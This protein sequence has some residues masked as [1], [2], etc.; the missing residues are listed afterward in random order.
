MTACQPHSILIVEDEGIVAKDMQQTLRELGYDAYAIASG[1]DDAVACASERCPDLVLMDIRIKGERDGIETAQLL[2]DRFAVPIVYLTAH[3]DDATL[4]RAKLTAPHGYLVKPVK[5]AELRSAIEVSLYKHSLEKRQQ[6]RE[7]WYATTL[8][9]IADAVVAVDVKGTVTFMNPAAEQLT[10]IASDAAIGRPAR[11]VVRLI[12]EAEAA[13]P[14]DVALARGTVVHLTEAEL[15]RGKDGTRTISDSVAPVVDE[16]KTLGAVMVFR[17]V[18]EQR[19]LQK[20]LEFADRLASLGTMAAGVAHEVNNPLTVVIGNVTFARDELARVLGSL[21]ATGTA[22]VSG[23]TQL[24][25]ASSAL[26][27]AQTAAER[28]RQV[29]TDLRAFARPASG[30]TTD[31]DVEKAL[32][33]ALRT[34]AHEFRNRAS[35]VRD[36]QGV[37]RVALDEARLGQVLI[38]L[39]VNAAHAIEPG[40]AER[41][42]VSIAAHTTA[43]GRVAIEVRDTGAGIPAERQKQIFEPFFTTKGFGSGT[44]LGLSI[45]HGIVSSAG[46]T[47]RVDSSVGHG[48]VFRVMLPASIATRGPSL[49]SD[50]PDSSAAETVR[51]RVLLIDDEELILRTLARALR[52]H[53]VICTESARKALQLLETEPRFDVIFS[54]LMMPDMTGMEFYE[55]LRQEHPDLCERVV[56]VSGGASSPRVSDFLS[57]VSNLCVDKPFEL[58]RLKSIVRQRVSANSARALQR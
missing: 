4:D 26:A 52:A 47:L 46:G 23:N 24:S 56:F 14:I 20:Q 54:D 2:T 55:T 40:Q 37:L 34:T 29:V 18:T 41:N 16:G 21:D 28:I 50:A 22:T 12:G 43:D 38:N 15:A 10:E 7:R 58:E 39:L 36:V 6:Q 27:E 8:L 3:A 44:G 51:G 25:D 9:S 31:C 19:Q 48:S 45:C 42:R 35:V 30:D 1:A 32:D 5:V 49:V 13:F 11:D 57:S 53:D 17:D 33:W